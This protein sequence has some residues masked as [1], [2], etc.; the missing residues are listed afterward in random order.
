MKV[1]FPRQ[2]FDI[3]PV[4]AELHAG[5]RTDRGTNMTRLIVAFLNFP[6][7]HKNDF[8]PFTSCLT[9]EHV[10]FGQGPAGAYSH[11]MLRLKSTLKAKM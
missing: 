2:I 8:P 9:G 7:G 11:G 3:R 4:G 6:N 5:G 10:L 1:E